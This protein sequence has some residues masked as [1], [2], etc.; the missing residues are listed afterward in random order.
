MNHNSVK[1][2]STD[3]VYGTA[4]R[5]LQKIARGTG[6]VFF[7]T[8]SGMLLGFC[9]RILFARFF[10]QAEYGIYSLALVVLNITVMF[11]TFGLQEGSARQIASY[12]SK[13]DTEKVQ[14]VIISS[15]QMA[16]IASTVFSAVLFFTSDIISTKIFHEA[17]LSAPL[18]IFS[19][20]VPF[21]SLIQILT[22]F[23]RGFNKVKP[24]VYFQDILRS[25]VFLLSLVFIILLGLS[26]SMAMYAFLVSI[27]FTCLAFSTY[28]IKKLPLNINLKA[29]LKTEGKELLLFSL[30]LFATLILN[31]II[32]WTDILM[33]G[34]YK[35]SD[36]VG[37]YNAA[38]PIA[39]LLPIPLA[40]LVFIYTP[41]CSQLFSQK[42]FGEMKRNYNIATKWIF[43]AT[44][45]LFLV[46]FFFPADVLKLLFGI[47]Y[48]EASTALK[49]LS[50][51]FF[52]HTFLGPNGA[53]LTAMGRTKLLMW[54]SLSAAFL[55]IT[56][57]MVLIPFLGI[58]GAA[59]ASAS[60]LALANII[61]S[62]R[63]YQLSGIHPFSKNYL[64]PIVTSVIIAFVI[65]TVFR[66]SLTVT[67]WILPV[68]VLSFL[69]IYS[70]AF[71][72]TKSFDREDI[73]ML[74]EIE[75]RM[76]LNLS[77]V[78]R[79]LKRFM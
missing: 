33:L 60:A 63:L 1:S 13:G 56:A 41:V 45:P 42:L 12:R 66:N 71:L 4:D 77:V 32:T 61:N 52:I 40:S 17:D 11:S 62:T 72:L 25:G 22:S 14:G 47:K 16:L 7:G 49:I 70:F 79:S 8:I 10:S 26:F 73:T 19:L 44:L 55:N 21:F 38:L 74:L 5:S 9:E 51:G 59:I 35:T 76:G 2:M 53:T 20:A 48:I 69:V 64:K 57:N 37:L 6:I 30:P 36:T 67:L 54:A 23:F 3:S 34:Y 24:K 65:H 43:A 18:K 58:N 28:T 50:L 46:V 15:L 68:L 29:R 31:M 78:K 39:R 27:V 75:K